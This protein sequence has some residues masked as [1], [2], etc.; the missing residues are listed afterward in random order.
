MVCILTRPITINFTTLPA[1]KPLEWEPGNGYL[2]TAFVH[3][4]GKLY[5]VAL[6]DM[7]PA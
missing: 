2:P 4:C 5:V 1:G 3:Y 6:A 7:V